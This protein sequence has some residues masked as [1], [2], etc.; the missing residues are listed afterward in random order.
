MFEL[1][2]SEQICL[3]DVGYTSITS[4]NLTKENI[5]NKNE[6]QNKANPEVPAIN[7]PIKNDKEYANNKQDKNG[8]PFDKNRDQDSDSE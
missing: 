6:P 5:M 1:K 8:K 4:I 2:K 3:R 7:Q